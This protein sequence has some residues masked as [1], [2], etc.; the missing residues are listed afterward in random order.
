MPESPRLAYESLDGHPLILV[1]R[2]LAKQHRIEEAEYSLA[3]AR[4][5]SKETGK[6][7]ATIQRELEEIRLAVEREERMKGGWIDCFKP[8]NKTLYRTLLGWFFE[9]VAVAQIFTFSKGMTLQMFQQLTGANYFFY[10]GAT[11]FK[12]VGISDSFVT[13]IILGTVNFLC[14]FLGLYIMER[15][16]N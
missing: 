16:R 8:A 6:T 11:I 9:F 13:Q 7:H 1:Y 12:S 5:L 3:R 10:Y 4:G 2:W 14:T 15:V